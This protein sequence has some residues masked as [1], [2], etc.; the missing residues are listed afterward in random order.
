MAKVAPS[1]PMTLKNV[2][3]S[4]PNLWNKAVFEGKE[5]KYEATLLIEAGSKQAK[6]IEA[7]AKAYAEEVFGEGKVPKSL[8]FTSLTDGNTKDYEGYEDMLAFKGGSGKRIPIVDR[9]GKTPI[10]EDDEKLEAGDYVN[11]SIN[12]W[13]SDHPKGGKQIL[14]NIRAIQFVKEGERF[15]AGTVNTDD[16]F[17]ELEDEEEEY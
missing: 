4:F 3:L 14:G 13:Y 15:G 10:T 8:K 17:E 16:L 5:T 11:A 1:K 12:F 7:L 2:R 9:D 6:E